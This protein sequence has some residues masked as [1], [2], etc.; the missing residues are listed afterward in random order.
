MFWGASR[1]FSF[2]EGDE[3]DDHDHVVKTSPFHV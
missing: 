2:I 3:S 1:M